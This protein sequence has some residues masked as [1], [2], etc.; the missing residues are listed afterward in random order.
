M[1]LSEERKREVAD[2]L[3][4]VY[5]CETEESEWEERS[6][7]WGSG[8]GCDG[9]AF[10]V[11]LRSFAR[12]LSLVPTRHCGGVEWRDWRDMMEA[13][14]RGQMFSIQLSLCFPCLEL[15]DNAMVTSTT[16]SIAFIHSFIH[17]YKHQPNDM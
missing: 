17:F 1:P 13:L 16:L 8:Y 10:F 15:Y 5:A 4:Q 11:Q 12:R 9:L 6:P 2:E 3:D 14:Q 7:D